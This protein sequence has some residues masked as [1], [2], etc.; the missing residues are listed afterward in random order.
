[1][2]VN[3]GFRRVFV[4]TLSW[5]GIFCM[6]WQH[7]LLPTGKNAIRKEQHRCPYLRSTFHRI[8]GASWWFLASC[9]FGNASAYAHIVD[10]CFIYSHPYW[11]YSIPAF[12]HSA[13]QSGTGSSL[14]KKAMFYYHNYRPTLLHHLPTTFRSPLCRHC[15]KIC[16]MT[17]ER[18]R[19]TVLPFI[20]TVTS[21]ISF[22]N[23]HNRLF[24][25]QFEWFFSPMRTSR[26]VCV[27]RE[28]ADLRM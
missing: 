1:M 25:L 22:R 10:P 24:V 15:N 14:E 19:W 9:P 27:T 26:G 6:S 4:L 8:A 2:Q 20:S 23:K 5:V 7:K 21:P 11:V 18:T 13:F 17:K 12:A 3:L 16:A 28:I